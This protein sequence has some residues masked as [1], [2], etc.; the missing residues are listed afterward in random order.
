[1]I[2]DYSISIY[3]D[4]RRKK[5]NGKYP[6]KLRVFIPSIRKQKLYPTSFEFT[7]DEFEKI[8]KNVRP[9]S[10]YK[11]AQMRLKALELFANETADK[12]PYF[13][14]EKFELALYRK[15]HSNKGDLISL[16]QGTIEQYKSN[17]QIGTAS[18]YE[19]SLSS[20]LQFHGKNTL[21]FSDISPQWLKD[22]ERHMVNIKKRSR[23]TVG[24]Y[25]RPLRA[26]FNTAIENGII[27]QDLYPFGRRKYTIPAPTSTKKA[28]TNEQLKLLFEA[29]PNTPEQAKAKAFWFFSYS[30]NGMNF[31]DIANIRYQDII[32]DTLQ[33]RRAKTENT[34]N[35]QAPVVVYLSDFSKKVIHEYGNANKS[36]KNYIF[37]IVEHTSSPETMHKQLKNFIRFINQHFS[38]FAYENGIEERVSTYWARHSFATQAIRTGASMEYVSEALSHSNLI[39][40]RNYFAGFED[41]KKKEISKRMLEF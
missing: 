4:V 34:N 22:Y 20:L 6:V 19:L 21:H 39:T 7:D 41:E 25:L 12:L 13:T 18:N 9:R 16:Y 2:R 11:D 31:K 15:S 40:T 30:C 26:I 17:N 23:T 33:F 27:S 32:G 14:L 10:A 28:L 36:P 1:M 8:W 24:I 3:L 5:A 35:S 29:E 38:K 37:N